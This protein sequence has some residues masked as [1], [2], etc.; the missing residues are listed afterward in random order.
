MEGLAAGK[1]VADQQY[2]YTLRSPFTPRT[3]SHAKSGRSSC[4]QAASRST[5][6]VHVKPVCQTVIYAR[7]KE[8][9]NAGGND[10]ENGNKN[11]TENIING[12]E[13]G[14]KTERSANGHV[15]I[16]CNANKT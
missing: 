14:N 9:R 6:Q 1:P 4:W 12:T 5:V 7:L 16:P 15:L 3:P 10:T 11:G 8:K 2:R 13:N